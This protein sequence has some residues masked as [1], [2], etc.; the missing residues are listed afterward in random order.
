MM[1][2]TYKAALRR[3]KAEYATFRHRLQEAT[4]QQEDLEI[5]LGKLRETIFAL[6]RITGQPF[7]EQEHLG[8]T[9]AIR[10]AFKTAPGQ[11]MT[12]IDVRAR[13]AQLG[14]DFA[15]HSNVLASIHT[16]LNRLEARR[17][18]RSAGASDGKKAF[19][20]IPRL[21]SN[22]LRSSTK[23]RSRPNA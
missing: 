6:S 17:E 18:I 20:W 15:G 8:F 5:H 11:K 9:D 12:A 14:W 13:L 21:G 19:V 2:G 22:R 10:L 4:Q 23:A 1:S 16:I 7:S 3:A